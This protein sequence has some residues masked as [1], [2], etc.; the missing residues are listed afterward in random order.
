M[1]LTY[2]KIACPVG[3][4]PAAPI[5]CSPLIVSLQRC[6][7][8]SCPPTGRG[9]PLRPP[10]P[11]LLMMPS[12]IVVYDPAALRV[13]EEDVLRLELAELGA[14]LVVADAGALVVG[15]GGD[16]RPHR[17][18]LSGRSGTEVREEARGGS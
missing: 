7:K 14:K 17:E 5:S 1:I 10:S 3:A 15:Q 11:L 16:A 12:T 6:C 2:K 8:L 13:V 18:V 9:N 4:M